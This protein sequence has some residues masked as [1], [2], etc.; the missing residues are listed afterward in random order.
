MGV[1]FQPSQLLHLLPAQEI[2]EQIEKDAELLF[3][4][5]WR[6]MASRQPEITVQLM[7]QALETAD[8]QTA[9]KQALATG[10]SLSRFQLLLCDTRC[11]IILPHWIKVLNIFPDVYQ[12]LLMYCTRTDKHHNL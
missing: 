10:E 8:G 5:S 11:S 1:R 4:L 12:Q 2:L 3:E 6:R 7:Q 9:L